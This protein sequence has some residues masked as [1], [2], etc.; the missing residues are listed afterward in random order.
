MRAKKKQVTS[1]NV[2]TTN[3]TNTTESTSPSASDAPNETIEV[4]FSFPDIPSPSALTRGS[5]VLEPFDDA[6][7]S[8]DFNDGQAHALNDDYTFNGGPR[9]SIFDPLSSHEL[10]LRPDQQSPRQQQISSIGQRQRNS[11]YSASFSR[12]GS[13]FDVA[14]LDFDLGEYQSPVPPSRSREYQPQLPFPID[15]QPRHLTQ[16]GSGSQCVMACSQ[17]IISLEKYLVAELKVLDLVLGIVKRVIEILGPLVEH[18]GSSNVK[19]LA[20]FGT[21]MYQI[22]ELVEAG[23]TNFLTEGLVDKMADPLGDNLH[24]FGFG[25][26]NTG[27]QKRFSCQIVLEEL[28]PIAEIIRK[29][30]TLSKAKMSGQNSQNGT[31]EKH[32]GCHEDMQDR[33]KILMEKV[34]RGGGL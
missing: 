12:A 4:N 1:D 34:K 23:C 13:E 22:L 31:G 20:L 24:D 8:P 33:L 17:I 18:L 10:E 7:W 11:P 21:I 6:N 29:V 2:A 14:G 16:S 30:V 19:C 15:T 9:D 25:T 26:F 32:T 27:N 3:P 28:Q 5:V